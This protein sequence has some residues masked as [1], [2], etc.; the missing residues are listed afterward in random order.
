MFVENVK[1]KAKAK[2]EV[3]KNSFDLTF[4]LCEEPAFAFWFVRFS[5]AK[6]WKF[7]GEK[8]TRKSES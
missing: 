6:F 4:L 5:R 1:P 2:M 3:N 7:E 8:N